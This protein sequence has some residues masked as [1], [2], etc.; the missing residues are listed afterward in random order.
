MNPEIIGLIATV[1]VFVSLF[2]KRCK[3][4]TNN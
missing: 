2:A 3:M 4:D 1:F